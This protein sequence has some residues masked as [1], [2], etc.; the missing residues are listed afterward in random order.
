MLKKV[1]IGVPVLVII[2]SIGLWLWARAV[3]TQDTV[4]TALAAQLSTSLG[5]PV[6][7]GRVGAT[8]YPRV[9]VNLGDVAIGQPP[10]IRV[11]TLHIG[12]DFGALLSR[13][14]EHAALRLAGARIELPLP[15]F[16]IASPA[17]AGSGEAPTSAPVEIES[18]DEIVLRDVE[19]ISGGRT[20]RGDIEIVPKGKGITLRKVTL[21]AD[22]TTIDMTGQITDLSRPAGELAVKAGRLNFDQLLAFVS[23]FVS[24]AG[25]GA[26]SGARP[27]P[28][29]QAGAPVAS[30]AMNIVVSLN[31]DSATMGELS[32]Q[33]LSGRARVTS[34]SMTL[35]PISFGL[36]GG[37]YEG[38]L[39]LT[40]GSTTNFRL[41]A[42]LSG[43]DMAAATRFAGS[44][45]TITGRLSG[46]INLFGRGLDAG[47]ILKTARGTARVD[48][49]NG[50]VKRLGL[51]RTV[52]IAT[53]GRSDAPSQ[54]AGA[55]GDEPFARLGATLSVA[56]GSAG[57]EDLR[58]E[59]NDL[60]L[61]AAGAVRL[62]GS[63]INLS[64]H[65]QLSDKLSQQAGRDL[66]RY[67]QEGGR[68]TLPVTITGSADNPQVRIDM[69][70]VARRAITNR[71]R[72]EAEKAIKKG[73]GG[74]LGR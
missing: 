28:P 21:S 24:S 54:S 66:V 1:L 41:N 53:S 47:T 11:Q 43:V 58:F 15:D 20:L 7:I 65:V 8:I 5:Q 42:T 10:R 61:V 72:E 6:T 23:D 40:L 68:V 14:I 51:V 63:A 19:I 12:T 56:E 3:F 29:P 35:E 50:T 13:R 18:I 31:A 59:S 22:G 2:A 38:A 34:D 39:A 44:P 70:S 9:T 52:V 32:L 57:T 62:D 74:L 27:V 46:K 36:F 48:I 16:A 60:L 17:A 71:A 37:A 33:K 67:T 49:T 4:R 73:L 26:S 69:A 55:S 45:D 64:G 25:L 30:S